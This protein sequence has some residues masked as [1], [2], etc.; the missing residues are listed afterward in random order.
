MIEKFFYKLIYTVS[1]LWE[2]LNKT[3]MHFIQ[4]TFL[5]HNYKYKFLDLIFF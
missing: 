3:L 2:L 4:N 1:V 5:C